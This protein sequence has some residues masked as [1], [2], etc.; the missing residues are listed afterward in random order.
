VT[1]FH[2]SERD[3]TNLLGYMF[4][5]VICTLNFIQGSS[6]LIYT[7]FVYKEVLH[8]TEICTRIEVYTHRSAHAGP[9]LCQNRL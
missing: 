7:Y 3:D 9:E 8:Y 1:L 2:K 4:S 6:T 5:I